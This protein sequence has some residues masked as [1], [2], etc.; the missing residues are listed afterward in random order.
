[1]KVILTGATGFIGQG[2]LL[3][4]IDSEA[5]TSIVILSRRL[6]RKDLASNEKVKVVI[7]DDFLHLTDEVVQ[8]CAGAEGCIWY[9][10]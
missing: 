8:E 3:Q 1:M 6:V 7:V 2:A 5:I 10:S 4:C 9:A